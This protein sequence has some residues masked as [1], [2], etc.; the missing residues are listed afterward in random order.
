MPAYLFKQ[1]FIFILS[2]GSV[3]ATKRQQAQDFSA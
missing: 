2:L 1:A 3:V